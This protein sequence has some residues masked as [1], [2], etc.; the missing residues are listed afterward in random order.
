[1]SEKVETVD[2]SRRFQDIGKEGGYNEKD[3]SNT[4]TV[5]GGSLNHSKSSKEEAFAD[6]KVNANGSA[7]A[8]G[9]YFDKKTADG[10]IV[11]TEDSG[12][13]S[14]AYCFKKS[15]KWGIL[16]L[17]VSVLFDCD[18]KLTRRR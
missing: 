17:I 5:D 8:Q 16:T 2:T 1:M 9:L 11:L 10:R 15:R 18:A 7:P 13:E 4:N 12:Y 6:A 14:T 3:T